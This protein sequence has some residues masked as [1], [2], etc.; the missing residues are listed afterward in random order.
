[1]IYL[2][3]IY[4]IGILFVFLFFNGIGESKGWWIYILVSVL[5]PLVIIS[6]ISVF[7]ISFITWIIKEKNKGA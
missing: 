6:L 5:W 4:F 3:I 7:L 2:T 1:M